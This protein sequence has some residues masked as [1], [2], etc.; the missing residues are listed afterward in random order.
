[1]CGAVGPFWDLQPGDP[2]QRWQE[3]AMAPPEEVRLDD[4]SEVRHR[5]MV[6]LRAALKGIQGHMWGY[7][8]SLLGFGS[9]ILAL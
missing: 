9:A 5:F 2:F 3:R 7:I 8:D 1:M 4:I 6:P